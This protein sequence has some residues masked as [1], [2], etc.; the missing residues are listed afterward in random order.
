M[1]KGDKILVWLNWRSLTITQLSELMDAPRQSVA[2]ANSHNMAVG[3]V[4]WCKPAIQRTR[5]DKLRIT[6]SGRD[7]IQGLSLAPKPSPSRMI[8]ADLRRH[9][10]FEVE[11]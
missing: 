2:V 8:Q 4:E 9:G 3:D 1:K 11:K 6:Q 10:F 7:K 5:S